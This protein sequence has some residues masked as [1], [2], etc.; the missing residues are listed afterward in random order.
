VLVTSAPAPV[1]AVTVSV[2]CISAAGDDQQPWRVT[3]EAIACGNGERS[4][5]AGQV[6]VLA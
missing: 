4:V 2:F 6:V 5:K 3:V 1:S